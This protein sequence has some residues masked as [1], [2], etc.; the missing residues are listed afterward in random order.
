MFLLQRKHFCV[1][2]RH[3]T[4]ICIYDSFWQ[5][6]AFEQITVT[7]IRRSPPFS[8]ASSGSTLRPCT[9]DLI[10]SSFSPGPPPDSRH[11]SSGS[12]VPSPSFLWPLFF[13]TFLLGA[14][15]T[16]GAPTTPLNSTPPCWDIFTPPST[17]GGAGGGS[18]GR[19]TC[20]G[21]SRWG[22]GLRAGTQGGRTGH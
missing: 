18:A 1:W 7:R 9:Q 21:Q 8:T 13:F 15:P 4:S 10:S 20:T 17:G 5:T 11:G 19:K 3:R 22:D 14:R 12:A 2:G 16:P 6:K